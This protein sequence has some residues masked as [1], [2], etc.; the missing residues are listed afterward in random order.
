MRL[1]GQ[2]LW[3]FYERADEPKSGHVLIWQ[4]A[5]PRTGLRDGSDALIRDSSIEH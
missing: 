2:V 1:T 3:D 5:R 4:S